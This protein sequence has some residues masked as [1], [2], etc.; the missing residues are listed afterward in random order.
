ML[1][2]LIAFNG[3]F[4]HSCPALFYVR[5]ALEENLPDCKPEIQQFTIN[6]PYYPTLRRIA[7]GEPGAFFFSVYIWNS[8]YIQRLAGDLVKLLPNTPIILG[9]PQAGPLTRELTQEL[10]GHITVVRGEIEGIEKSFYHDLSEKSLKR[11]YSCTKASIFTS[12][13]RPDDFAG[14]LRNRHVYY[15]SSRGCPFGCT[16]CLSASEKGVRHLPTLQVHDELKAI[17]RFG[18]KVIRFVDRT[19][20]DQPERALDIW[21]FLA[22]QPGKTLFHFEMA[23]DRFSE[24]M[25]EFL[26][27]VE[28]GRFQFELGIQSTNTQTLE[29][30]NRKCDLAKVAANIRKLVA[31]DSIHIHLDL[32]LGLPYENRESFMRSFT[33]V[34]MLGPH[35]IQMGLLKVLPDTPISRDIAANG[36]VVC[37]SPPYEV[38]ANRWLAPGELEELF[39]FGECVEAFFNNRFFRSFWDYLRKTNEDVFVFFAALLKLCRRKS[40]FDLAHTQELLSSLLLELTRG[41]DDR[42]MLRELLIFDWLRCGHRFLPPH[43][44]QEPIADLK[45]MLWKQMGQSCEGLY[46]Y[47]SRDEFFK[48]GVFF[49]FTGEF[50]RE[51]G[52]TD[53]GK[54]AYVCF[55]PQR[56]N[57]VFRLNRFVLLP[58]TIFAP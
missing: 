43:L 11:Q 18:P 34:F 27:Q 12:P 2:R 54:G 20:N 10:S 56:E 57:T 22:E 29:A 41:R 6:D 44:E 25:F 37:E 13:Y 24:E 39:W 53:A 48:Q 55:Q 7:A 31:L 30:V 21:R 33:D 17:L 9:G 35:Y 8:T 47:K 51:R 45:K 42:E 50:L 46:D 16:Y 19:F 15:E 1:Y 23:P 32:I 3:R 52:L 28:P 40:F 58:A 38:L 26:Q 49:R 4:I 14:H 5:A 36:L